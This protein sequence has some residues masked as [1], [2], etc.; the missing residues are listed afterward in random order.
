MGDVWSYKETDQ[1][2][3][4]YQVTSFR[5]ASQ[6]G[7]SAVGSLITDESTPKWFF[8][9]DAK[10]GFTLELAPSNPAKL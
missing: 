2:A 10:G 7:P 8:H 5:D 6:L 1:P 9:Q 3:A 4:L